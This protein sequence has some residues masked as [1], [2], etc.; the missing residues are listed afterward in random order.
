MFYYAELDSKLKVIAVHAL[1]AESTNASYVA[2][3]EEQ[4]NGNIVNK[5]YN[6]LTGAFEVLDIE[7]I[8]YIGETNMVR[9]IDSN[10]ILSTKL[11]NMQYEINQKATAD[12]SHE[13]STIAGL[14]DLLL[15]DTTGKQKVTITGNVL[16]TI[17]GLPAGVHTCYS[18]GGANATATNAPNNIE[19]WRYLI[20][21]NYLNYGWIMAFGS[22]GSVFTNY[23]DAG[24]W[25]GWKPIWDNNPSPLWSGTYYMNENQTIY[26]SKKLSECKNGWV[27]LWS[28]YT[29]GVAVNGDVVA[30]YIPKRCYDG[31]NWSGHSWL[32][33]VPT[34]ANT[35]VDTRCNKK[36][37]VWNDRL[38][39]NS[40]NDVSPR[41]NVVL[42]AVYEF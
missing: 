14:L 16:T 21:K 41:N 15:T 9:E 1:E 38:V 8:G 40:I 13:I 42:R 12:H 28:D 6:R 24:T 33:D 32:A 20:H 5:F 29:N 11:D 4:Y 18:A 36:L 3:T 23:Y 7:G 17:A 22:E 2:I 19:S 34:E 10:M 35:S 30:T 39:G 37:Y 25:R 26:P 31:A 27:L